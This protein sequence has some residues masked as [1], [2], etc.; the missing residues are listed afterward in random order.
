MAIGLMGS[1][2]CQNRIHNAFMEMER[3]VESGD[4]THLD[5]RFGLCQSLSTSPQL[6]VEIFFGNMAGPFSG[7]VQYHRTGDME[8]IC[9]YLMAAHADDDLE[10]LA[11]TLYGRP[12]QEGDQ[13]WNISYELEVEFL[14]M[15]RWTDVAGSY[16]S[17]YAVFELTNH[18]ILIILFSSTMDLPNLFRVWMVSNF[19]D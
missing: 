12:P 16:S 13:C 14:S 7:W 1:S 10:A 11:L 17:N 3:I 15:T 8:Y 9:D 5:K 18:K 2:Q 19:L 4:T 6:D